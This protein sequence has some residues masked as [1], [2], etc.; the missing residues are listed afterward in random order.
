MRLLTLTPL[1]LSTV[2]SVWAAPVPVSIGEDGSLSVNLLRRTGDK[3]YRGGVQPIM[4]KEGEMR[5]DSHV[6]AV[7]SPSRQILDCCLIRKM[8][9]ADA[10]EKFNL[11]HTPT[12][13]DDGHHSL[14][15]K[16]GQKMDSEQL[17]KHLN[18]GWTQ[19]PAHE[20]AQQLAAAKQ[21][22]NSGQAHG[23]THPPSDSPHGQASHT[24][25]NSQQHHS[26]PPPASPKTGGTTR[27][28]AD[29]V[30]GNHP[31]T[32]QHSQPANKNHGGPHAASQGHTT[33]PSSHR[34]SPPPS[35][36]HAAP[37]Q[38]P[39]TH[40]GTSHASPGPAP[41]R[42]WAQVVAG[43]PPAHKTTPNTQSKTH[44][45]KP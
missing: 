24:P 5:Q 20:R 34:G 17:Q 8:S 12:K 9:K 42:S 7:A 39:A 28:W 37:H 6:A 2:A 27:S 29:V 15:L 45:K 1:L 19:T 35:P 31:A 26:T 16:K 3:I 23:G 11:K 25:S 33:P 43:S 36:H 14:T 38:A 22:Q 18:D 41:A 10:A 44:G 13:D 30:A 40:Q 21:G 4:P 32:Q